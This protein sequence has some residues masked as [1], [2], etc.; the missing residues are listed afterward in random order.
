VDVD[1]LITRCWSITLYEKSYDYSV[2][3]NRSE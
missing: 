2:F 3:S 1:T